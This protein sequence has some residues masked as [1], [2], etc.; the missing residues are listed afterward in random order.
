MNG[1][2]KNAVHKDTGFMILDN[3][4]RKNIPDSALRLQAEGRE[5]LQKILTRICRVRE[6]GA[7]TPI[8]EQ[9]ISQ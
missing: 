3:E 1:N 5:L 8:S 4:A 7:D 2:C 9:P 6:I